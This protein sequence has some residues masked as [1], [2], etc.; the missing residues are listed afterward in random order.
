M[1]HDFA[2]QKAFWSLREC[3]LGLVQ[4]IFLTTLVACLTSSFHFK[5]AEYKFQAGAGAHPGVFVVALPY[6]KGGGAGSSLRAEYAQLEAFCPD[7][8]KGFHT[9]P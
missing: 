8:H 4:N 3:I 6:P 1:D 7:M 9:P 5:K 2:G